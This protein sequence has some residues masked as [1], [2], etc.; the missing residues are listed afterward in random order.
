MA[1]EAL[2]FSVMTDRVAAVRFLVTKS[3]YEASR[4]LEPNRK[5]IGFPSSRS[6]AKGVGIYLPMVLFLVVL[7]KAQ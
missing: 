4:H 3:T 1:F 2:P 5:G 7:I 6:E